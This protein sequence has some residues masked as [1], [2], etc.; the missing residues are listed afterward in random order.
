MSDNDKNTFIFLKNPSIRFNK[1]LP[2]REI[3]KI[4]DLPPK[5]KGNNGYYFGRRRFQKC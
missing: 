1:Y 4:D 2:P 5:K 3:K